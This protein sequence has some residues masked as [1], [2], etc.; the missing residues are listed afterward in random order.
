[1]VNYPKRVLSFVV[2]TLLLL[3]ALPS[4]VSATGSPFKDVKM[5][6]WAYASIVWAYNEGIIKG[7][8]NGT[9]APDATL[10]EAQFVTLLVRFDHSASVRSKRLL[11]IIGICKTTGCR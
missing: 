5:D 10:T 4:F 6:H 1:M 11:I 9:F 3:A 7:Y 2:M 8:P